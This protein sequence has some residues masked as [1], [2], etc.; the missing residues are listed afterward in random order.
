[1]NH[2]TAA[3]GELVSSLDDP[4]SPVQVR[5]ML[6]SLY[7][8][9]N[10]ASDLDKFY[11]T[12]LEKYPQSAFWYYRAGL[13]YL[14][15]EDFPKAQELLIASWQI[16]WQQ[17]R[18]DI[19]VLSAY[20]ESLYRGQKYDQ[21]FSMASDLI[22]SPAAPLAYTFMAQVQFQKGQK[23]KAVESFYAALDKAETNDGA[24]G[25]IL[26]KML[27]TVGQEAPAAWISKK[28]AAD[29]NSLPA[30]LLAVRLAERE[31]SYNKAI[32]HINKCI[33]VLGEENPARLDYS[34]R[35]MNLLIMAYAKTA[36]QDYWDRATAMLEKMLQL[37]PNNSSLLNNM[38]YLLAD[39]DQQLE[40]ALDYARKAHQ[41]DPGNPVF[42]DTY[43][44]V[45]CKTGQYEQAEQN[46]IRAIQIY[47]ASGQ[48]VPW[49]LYKHFGM[50]Q[51]GLGEAAQAIEMYQKALEASDEI[52]EKEKQQL[53][54]AIEQLQR[55]QENVVQ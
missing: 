46:L 43:A 25:M 49:D 40:T 26:Q 54:V 50:A 36:D 23:D 47:E 52:S 18:P 4:Q 24:Q 53:R 48:P 21:I 29:E 3:I 22:D 10:R 27:D 15:Q 39:N 5:L 32:E 19:S 2:V 51:E 11:Q 38:A 6:E 31:N 9:N 30:H 28:L 45:Q 37:Q 35:K 55:S 20:F 34:L 44:H 17:G 8:N 41:G 1:M 12:T 16:S 14:N 7:Q 42:L 13:Y 33:D